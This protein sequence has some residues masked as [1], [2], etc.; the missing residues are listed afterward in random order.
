MKLP[1]QATDASL[2]PKNLKITHKIDRE[3][4]VHF[5]TGPLTSS[6]ATRFERLQA[7]AL[8]NAFD[9]P[10]D[11]RI[12]L[13]LVLFDGIGT[14]H[15]LHKALEVV[16]QAS[17]RNN[18]I[19]LHWKD[20]IGRWNARTLSAMTTTE[21]AFPSAD[22][23]I[24]TAT[25]TRL[26]SALKDLVVGSKRVYSLELLLLDAQSWLFKKLPGYL[27]AHVMNAAPL[28]ALPPSA[29]ARHDSQLA[30]YQPTLLIRKDESAPG[31][32]KA[33]EGFIA[34]V[35]NDIS[36]GFVGKIVS[37]CKRDR[38]LSNA[39]NKSHMLRN[40]LGLSAEVASAGPIS[41]LILAW[42][43]DLIESGTRFKANVKAITPAL[44]V[45]AA[46]VKILDV[47][48]GKSLEEIPPREFVRIYLDMLNGLSPSK[49]RRL[50]SALS[51]WHFFLSCWTEVEALPRSLHRNIPLTPPKANVIW[52]HEAN[53]IRIWLSET[54]NGERFRME[55]R[56]AFEIGYEIR[57]RA[58]EL[59]HL[60]ICDISIDDNQITVFI[61]T[62]E[63]DGGVKTLAARRPVIIKNPESIQIISEWRRRRKRE[64][65][66]DNDYLFGDPHA[67]AQLFRIGE[68]YF[69]LNK[70]LKSVT[71]DP[72]L[73][74][75][76]LS[77]TRISFDFLSLGNIDGIDVNPYEQGAALAGHR[78]AAT[79]FASYFHL[80][81]EQLRSILDNAIFEQFSSL[82]E[83]SSRIGISREAFRARCSREL[84]NS[85]E[86]TKGGLALSFVNCAAPT[87]LVPELKTLF[88]TASAVAPV[89]FSEREASLPEVLNLVHDIG[90]G[91]TFKE[92]T[93]RIGRSEDWVVRFANNAVDSLTALKEVSDALVEHYSA[94]AFAVLQNAL[95]GEAGKR[96]QVRRVAQAKVADLFATLTGGSRNEV[97]EQGIKSWQQCYQRG[98]LSLEQPAKLAGFIGLLEASELPTE[99]WRVRSSFQTGCQADRAISALFKSRGKSVATSNINH[100]RG[101]PHAYFVIDS[102]PQ[103]EE[104]ECNFAAARISNAAIGMCGINAVMF[105]AMTQRLM[106]QAKLTN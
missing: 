13:N 53:L 92:V 29:W 85:P 103:I 47:F 27:L 34:P 54:G 9:M 69:S 83:I 11:A 44:Y 41:S 57:I 63:N 93:L 12:A 39:E 5:R 100:R 55:L 42:A 37:A 3:G 89:I 38:S 77:H 73:G 56:V 23:I 91:F 45:R 72:T 19:G 94:D 98:Y 22:R 76:V 2:D 30:L 51:S 33:L 4:A 59:L 64:Y 31:F 46:A 101:R 86:K 99:F 87:L 82:H 20:E 71:G 88:T 16:N 17:S 78:S 28:S 102:M 74:T 104:P 32:S 105:A 8:Q 68:L 84:R 60:R 48:K 79:S 106:W 95:A 35:S 70:I 66:Y 80:F 25:I 81:E 65:A 21:L 75:H 90:E 15:D 10:T 62:R 96:L 26:D 97:I 52:P 6:A 18:S 43:I 14:H 58:N 61:A 7:A 36:I 24:P 1:L 49:M 40:C 67:P 50:A